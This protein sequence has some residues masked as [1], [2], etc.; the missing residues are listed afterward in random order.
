MIISVVADIADRFVEYDAYNVCSHV[1]KARACAPYHSLRS[2]VAVD[3]QDD[4]VGP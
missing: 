4:P 3:Y 2:A 1:C